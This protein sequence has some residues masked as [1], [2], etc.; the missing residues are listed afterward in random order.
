MDI[1]VAMTGRNQI[2]AGVDAGRGSRYRSSKRVVAEEV[3][4]LP[5]TREGREGGRVKD[6]ENGHVQGRVVTLGVGG[7]LLAVPVV[8]PDDDLTLPARCPQG[9]SSLVG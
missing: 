6:G 3:P 7:E 5:V 9:L 4:Q 2:Y 1:K 8:Q